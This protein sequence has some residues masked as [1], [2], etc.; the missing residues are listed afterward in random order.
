LAINLNFTKLTITTTPFP[1]HHDR[2]VVIVT[3]Y[4]L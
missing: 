4:D 3:G 2:K 1:N